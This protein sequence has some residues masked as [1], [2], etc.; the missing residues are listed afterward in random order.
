MQKY[1][2]DKTFSDIGELF[3]RA[4]KDLQVSAPSSMGTL[5]AYSFMGVGTS[6]KGKTEIRYQ[7]LGN[8]LEVFEESMKKLGGAKAGEKTFL[9]G[10]DPA[11]VVLK[12]AKTDSEAKKLLPKASEEAK[13]GSDN[14]ATMLAK[15]GRIAFKGEA[16]RTIVDPGSVF[17]SLMIRTLSE[18]FN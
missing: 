10:F 5:L 18:T 17:A 3:Y 12:G 16:S 6:Y 8:L 4:G 15:F 7:E 11:V 13:K 9:D 14:T 1:L 2:S